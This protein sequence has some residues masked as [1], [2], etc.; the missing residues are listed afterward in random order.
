[1]NLRSNAHC[2]TTFCDGKNTPEEMIQA[3]LERDF[4]SLGFSIHGWTP[5]EPTPVNME[6]EAEYRAELRRLR[7]KY[8]GQIEILIGAERDYLYERDFSGYEYL[9]D[10][11]HCLLREG[12]YL[13]VDRSEACTAENV[14]R[15]FGGDY[16]AYCRA[17]FAQE[18]EL[19]SRSDAAF[20][21]HIDLVRKFNAGNKHFDEDDP[22]YLAPAL[23]AAEI[24]VR[25]GLPI[26]MNSGAIN[27]GYQTT[28]YPG[29]A[30]LR[31]IR[32]LGGEIIINSDAHRADH[33]DG[34]FETCIQAARACGFDHALR[35]RTGGFEE[36]PLTD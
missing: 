26:E 30:L 19:C 25:R 33:L 2:H 13:F 20:I 18:A 31:R 3:A 7:E 8:R 6:K 28:P 12:E 11:A 21:G 9:I 17:Y 16:Y 22:R 34:G 5:Y 35:L 15:F 23:E 24:A 1:M 32:E 10:S 36:V 29:P 14:R 4:V 27:R